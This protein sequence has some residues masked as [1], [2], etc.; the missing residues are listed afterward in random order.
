M[1][2]LIAG[3]NKTTDHISMRLRLQPLSKKSLQDK[4]K[5]IHMDRSAAE[6]QQIRKSILIDK[7]LKFGLVQ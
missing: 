7:Q 5:T 1:D 4:T 6:M 3:N 2:H